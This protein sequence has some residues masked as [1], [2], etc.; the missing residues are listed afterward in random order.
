MGSA[1]LA[2][3]SALV[4]RG[5]ALRVREVMAFS[6]LLAAADAVRNLA[7]RKRTHRN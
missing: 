3:D 2:S 1:S 5:R 7:A 6:V 4:E